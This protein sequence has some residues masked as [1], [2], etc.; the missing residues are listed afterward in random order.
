MNHRSKRV[1]KAALPARILR[2]NHKDSRTILRNRLRIDG[3][4]LH[5][6]CEWVMGPHRGHTTRDENG[7][8]RVDS[9]G[10]AGD[11][12]PVLVWRL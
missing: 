12:R 8:E 1:F 2:I 4:G 3:I 6:A 10:A 7:R 11:Q 5:E 9:G